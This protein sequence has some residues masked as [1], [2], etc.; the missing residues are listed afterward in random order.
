MIPGIQQYLKNPKKLP[1]KP[2]VPNENLNSQNLDLDLMLDYQ[3]V[4]L[5]KKAAIDYIV[6]IFA[7]NDANKGWPW[8]HVFFCYFFHVS[9]FF[10]YLRDKLLSI[11]N[12][13]AILWNGLCNDFELFVFSLYSR[14]WQRTL[15]K[16]KTLFFV[17]KP[18]TQSW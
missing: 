10:K 9:T 14:V 13:D 5:L 16:S 12:K 15:A 1:I 3:N 7:I 18:N 4:I 2:D 17:V 8:F 11:S 6:F